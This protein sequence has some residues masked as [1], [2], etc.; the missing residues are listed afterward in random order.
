MDFYSFL[1]KIYRER[2]EDILFSFYDGDKKN[3]ITVIQW[4]QEICKFALW[5]QSRNRKGIHV[6]IACENRYEWYVM[7]FGI[8]LSGNVAVCINPDLSEEEM[9]Y[10]IEKSDIEEFYYDE[11]ADLGNC[12][13]TLDKKI[14]SMELSAARKIWN[15]QTEENILKSK[16]DS[17][18][19]DQ[20]CLILFSSGTKG[21]SK[22]VMLSQK[23]IL[24]MNENMQGL[25]NGENFMNILPQYH[26]AAVY[27]SIAFLRY[28]VTICIGDRT[29]Y[30]IRDILRFKPAILSLVP[31][32]LDFIMLRCRKNQKIKEIILSNLRYILSAGA[33]IYNEYT[34]LLEKWDIK[35]GNIYGLTEVSGGI[36]KWFPRVKG[37]IGKFGTENEIKL[38]DEEIVIRGPSVMNGYYKNPIEN[39]SAFQD[40]WFYTGDLAKIDKEGYVYVIGRSKNTIILSN[41]ENVN[42]EVLEQKI[43]SIQEVKEIIV[44]GRND[45]LEAVIYCGDDFT[46]ENKVKVKEAIKRMNKKLPQFQQIQRVTFQDYPFEKTASGKIKRL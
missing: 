41:G 17:L 20:T 38:V 35:L 5:M 2:P 19:K 3:D 40:G 34:E 45:I 8:A 21:L 9:L 4:V 14:L 31:S 10:Q 27:F 25:F 33:P 15:E 23:S 26:I 42:P 39:S 1:E 6:G 28:P 43:Q 44:T 46:E 24:N 16:M 32:Q 30:L 22:G 29:R 13:N 11:N 18:D 36:N 12:L 7:L 37:S